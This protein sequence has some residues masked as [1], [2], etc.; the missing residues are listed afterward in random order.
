MPLQSGSGSLL[1]GQLRDVKISEAPDG[2]S[3][4]QLLKAAEAA[5]DMVLTAAKAGGRRLF[6][7]AAQRRH[8][9]DQAAADPVGTDEVPRPGGAAAA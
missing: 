8:A 6:R 4:L 3:A 7:Q 5:R 1:K 9:A 2:T